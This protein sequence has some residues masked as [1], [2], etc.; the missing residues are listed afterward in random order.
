MAFTPDEI[1]QWHE[2]KRRR[3]AKSDFTFKSAPAA[4]CINCQN[5]FG[6]NEG[7]ITDEVAI[8]DVCNGD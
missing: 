2:E 5:P 6:T 1:R 4:I 7:V 3:E 8:C